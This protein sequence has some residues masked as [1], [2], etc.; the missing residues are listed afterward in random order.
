MITEDEVRE[1]ILE[2]FQRERKNSDD[3]FD[4]SRLL[5]FLTSPP[6]P[7]NSIKNSFRGVRRY[8]RF[9]GV[10]ELQFKICFTLSDLDRYYNVGS[11]TNKIIE[12]I[13]KRRGNLMII[14]QR[15]EE[16][17]RYWFE[18]SLTAIVT[19]IY[20]WLGL[21]WFPI[22]LTVV[23]GIGIWWILGSKIH[24]RQH[25]RKLTEILKKKSTTTRDKS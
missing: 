23:F 5:D 4:K 19:A 8:Y 20:I 12:R 2:L 1:K 16:K 24:D 18:L 11:L 25:T 6:H 9:M 21:H 17:T 14:R 7:Q 22:V 13:G 10:L 3:T 15:N